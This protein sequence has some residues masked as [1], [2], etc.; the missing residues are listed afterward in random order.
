ML[1]W[2]RL[3]ESHFSGWAWK[4]LLAGGAVVLALFAAGEVYVRV[5]EPFAEARPVDPN[6]P[7]A[8]RWR[9]R[10]NADSFAAV[11]GSDRTRPFTVAWIAGSDAI[12][13]PA[14]E[15]CRLSPEKFRYTLPEALAK[16]IADV[17]GRPF[18]SDG[19]VLTYIG[20][21]DMRMAVHHVIE[22]T[23]PTDVIIFS[24]NPVVVLDDWRIYGKESRQRPGGLFSTEAR[25]FDVAHLLPALRPSELVIEIM[26]RGLRSVRQRGYVGK[27][28]VPKSQSAF[29]FRPGRRGPGDTSVHFHRL[30]A[31]PLSKE[32]RKFLHLFSGELGP[33]GLAARY[34]EETLRDLKAHGAPTIV[35][36]PPINRKFRDNLAVMAR[37]AATEQR[38]EQIID[39][40]GASNIVADLS[41]WRTVP[42]PFT[43][44]D[45]IHLTCGPTVV[46]RIA[47][48]VA[49]ASGKRVTTR[50][51][52]QVYAPVQEASR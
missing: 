39:R 27:L 24:L 22:S 25:W 41:F 11:A 33:D 1:D 23:P 40:V 16:Q 32:E 28:D 30:K 46:D 50:P 26:G 29:P 20:I 47:D 49:R 31:L 43:I 38:L 44:R 17:D 36:I 10:A 48:L 14:L 37:M 18:R 34:L 52:D 9:A 19:Y 15:H 51:H 4:H 13:N 42:E 5:A 3:I 35:Y 45:S 6:V 2:A 7:V 8:M 12:V 21:G